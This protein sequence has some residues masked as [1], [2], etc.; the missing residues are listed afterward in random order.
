MALI[1]QL[2]DGLA[3]NKCALDKPKFSIGRSPNCDIFIDDTVVSSEHAVIEMIEN[4]DAAGTAKN[5]ADG[6]LVQLHF[7]I[8]KD[9]ISDVRMKVMG[10]VA[11]IASTSMLTEMVKKKTVEEAKSITKEML[12][13]KL[14]G[15]PENKIRCSL[16]C[17]DALQEAF[18]NRK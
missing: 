16:T 15:L 12:T 4:P 8:E 13:E 6:D 18:Q 10:C 5:E 11:A 17:I 1:V 7:K 14:G 9:K 3:I 2:H